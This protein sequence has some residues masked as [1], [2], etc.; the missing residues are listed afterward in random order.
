MN[1]KLSIGVIGCGWLGLPLAQTLVA[2]GYTVKGSATSI[3]R[4]KLLQNKGIDPYLVHFPDIDLNALE[5]LLGCDV[6]VINIPPR[7]KSPEGV[8]NYQNMADVITGK[9]SGRRVKKIIL[10][11]ST[12]VYSDTNTPVSESDVPVPTTVAG[13]LLLDVENQF[14]AVSDKRV[15][16][17]RL[18]GLVG[19]ERH[20]GAFFKN[21]SEIPNGLAPVNLIHREDVIGILLSMIR[22]PEIRGIYNGCSP[23]HPTKQQFYTTAAEALKIEAPE[24]I[25]ERKSYK[26]ISSVR[27]T[28]ELSY[29]FK[30]NDLMVWL[31]EKTES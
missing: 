3:E 6:L 2:S 29:S 4:L 27:I 28:E 14:L 20:P 5:N 9:V 15:A 22:N 13:K 1:N 11:S 16:V 24:F 17:L 19:P 25:S 26:I 7:S 8:A 30:Y 18:A 23:T 31:T 12:S 21:R 10:V